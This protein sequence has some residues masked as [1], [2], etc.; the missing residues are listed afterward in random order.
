MKQKGV[1]ELDPKL[2][3]AFQKG[4]KAIPAFEKKLQDCI[5][6]TMTCLTALG[7]SGLIYVKDG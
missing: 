7:K 5:S 2:A 3:Q 4:G 1:R 6:L